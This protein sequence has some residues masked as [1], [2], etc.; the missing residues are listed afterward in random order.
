MGYMPAAGNFMRMTTNR[1]SMKSDSLFSNE[2][3]RCASFMPG[4]RLASLDR[5][6]YFKNDAPC[7]RLGALLID[8]LP[9]ILASAGGVL[10][11][12]LSRS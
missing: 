6:K 10:I 1:K 7:W 4:S 2:L 11:V 8:R 5:L 9:A 3:K 12:Y